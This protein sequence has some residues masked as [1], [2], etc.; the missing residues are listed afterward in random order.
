MR[1]DQKK[2]LALLIGLVLFVNYQNYW[3]P[4]REKL[5]REIGL[6]KAKIEREEKLNATKIDPKKLELPWKRLFFDG[7]KLNYSQAMGA[8]QKMLQSSAGSCEVVRLTWAQV[9]AK[10]ER[11]DRLQMSLALRCP[12]RELFAF[13]N[14]LRTKGKL[15][16]LQDLRLMPTRDRKRLQLN[17]RIIAYRM[18]DE[19]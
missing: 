12:P 2:L 11:Y 14:R 6:L 10:A 1:V 16:R 8:L 17:A 3:A 9:P 18:H 5:S 19:Q 15:I 7:K 13:V 4:N